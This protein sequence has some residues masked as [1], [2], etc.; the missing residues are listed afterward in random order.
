M[1]AALVPFSLYQSK[2]KEII[3]HLCERYRIVNFGK[4]REDLQAVGSFE[5]ERRACY[6]FK[7]M[8]RRKK[9]DEY[10]F[11]LSIFIKYTIRRKYR[12]SFAVKSVLF[13][14]S[15]PIMTPLSAMAC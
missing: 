1:L 11:Y 14:G 5:I 7:K 3:E 13:S 2:S 6:S 15:L 10:R 12:R 4:S 8:D 9:N